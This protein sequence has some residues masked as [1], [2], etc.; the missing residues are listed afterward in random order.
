MKHNEEKFSKS[1][2]TRNNAVGIT[3]GTSYFDKSS[4]VKT[5]MGAKKSYKK[6]LFRNMNALMSGKITE[7]EFNKLQQKTIKNHFTTAFLLGKRFNQN[8]E[9]TLNDKERRMIVFQTTK[10]MDFMKRFAVDIQNR[11]G[12]M[13]YKRRMNM[14]ADGLDPMFRFA[15]IAY[16][17]ENIE[18]QWVLG[19]TDKHCFDCLF[20][21]AKSPYTK[22]TLPGVPKSC[23]SRC[24]VGN[25]NWYKVL[26]P[27]GWKKFIDV[28]I[29]DYVLSHKGKWKKVTKI[30]NEKFTD[31]YCY[32]VEFVTREK[33]TPIVVYMAYDHLSIRDKEWVRAENLATGDRLLFVS[34]KCKHC[35]KTIKYDDPRAINFEFCSISC[36]N[37]GNGDKWA[38]GRKKQLEKY[39]RFGIGLE[40]Y[41]EN[42]DNLKAIN[43][44]GR[45]ELEKIHKSRIGKTYEELYGKERADI[46]RFKCP[47]KAQEA[48]RKLTKDGKNPLNLFMKS[49]T[50]EERRVFCRDARLCADP[51][52]FSD[53]YER[54]VNDL[55]DRGDFHHTSAEKKMIVVLN[56]LNIKYET[57][58]RLENSFYDFYLPEYNIIIEVDGDYW[59]ANPELYDYDHLDQRQAKHVIK[60]HNKE[61]LAKKHNY[62]LYRFWESD[63]NNIESVYQKM[64]LIL[65]NHD[66]NFRGYYRT[67]KN[68]TKIK[69]SD[70]TARR[71]L[72]F[73]VE[74]DESYVTNNGLVAHNCMSNCL[75]RLVYYNGGV[76]TNYTNFILDNYTEARN[77]IPTLGQYTTMN[78]K[79]LAYYQTRLRYEVTGI[80]DYMDNATMIKNELTSFIKDNDLAVNVKF[81][82]ADMLHEARHYKKST[83]FDFLENTKDVKAG[84]FVATFIGNTHVYG[85]VTSVS[86]SKVVVDTLFEKGL[87]LDTLTDVI[88]KDNSDVD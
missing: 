51:A 4:T 10:E 22:K 6:E 53:L 81:T 34:H 8:T 48:M 17:P 49:M 67:I 25:T 60:D 7:D 32:K 38:K 47:K 78:D 21:A 66:G 61:E 46:L 40:K 23:N 68:I 28:R 59:H 16:L 80:A 79:L 56:E 9:T 36:S 74:G 19:V 69:T 86:G 37:K 88:F 54:K 58:L 73:T 45:K 3:H 5:F 30:I 12:K 15:D 62:Q 50:R 13:D 65:N 76:N 75:C 31:E 64:N 1:F 2:L 83:R 39:G 87:T 33:K 77:V 18:I 63:F 11:T 71:L 43:E 82:V 29:G 84:A 44:R 72:S 24:F 41:R 35:G 52:K 14:Y 70:L 26:T 27:D 57:Q 55:K 85:K 42:P 20:F